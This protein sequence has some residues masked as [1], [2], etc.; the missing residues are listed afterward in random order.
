MSSQADMQIDIL[1]V[2]EHAARKPEQ[3]ELPDHEPQSHVTIVNATIANMHAI[4]ISICSCTYARVTENVEAYVLTD[5]CNFWR[6]MNTNHVLQTRKAHTHLSGR[7]ANGALSTAKAANRRLVP[8]LRLMPKFP[9]NPDAA[10]RRTMADFV[11][12]PRTATV[13]AT[14]S[15][16]PRRR[17]KWSNPQRC[18]CRRCQPPGP[19]SAL[20]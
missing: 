15:P 18:C 13:C 10:R 12:R 2:Q 20:A 14:V 4:C 1:I 3:A 11:H 9:C 19:V 7:T 6:S 8:K 16:S 17:P 5:L